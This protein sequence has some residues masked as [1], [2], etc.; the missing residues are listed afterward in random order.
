MTSLESVLR[1]AGPRPENFGGRQGKA[2]QPSCPNKMRSSCRQKT[3][4]RKEEKHRRGS[5][6]KRQDLAEGYGARPVGRRLS[7][8]SSLTRDKKED[9]EREEV[10]EEERRES[11]DPV[12]RVSKKGELG[13]LRREKNVVGAAGGSQNGGK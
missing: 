10:K 13:G 7:K 3:T 4:G 12:H 2:T 9:G 6:E 1:H 8:C 11:A 5:R